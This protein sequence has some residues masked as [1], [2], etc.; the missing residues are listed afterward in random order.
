MF[1]EA[2]I[3][4]TWWTSNH[5]EQAHDGLRNLASFRFDLLSRHRFSIA[6][7]QRRIDDITR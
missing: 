6:N 1:P 2:W 5:I 4:A 3:M 7:P